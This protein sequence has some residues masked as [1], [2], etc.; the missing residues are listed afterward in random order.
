MQQAP[1][2]TPLSAADCK[3]LELL[4]SISKLLSQLHFKTLLG[5][6]ICFEKQTLT[7]LLDSFQDADIITPEQR[8]N[9]FKSL[10]SSK[11]LS[12]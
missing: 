10:E 3:H 11:W 1:F 4:H 9:F 6:C 5:N 7:M 2:P 8:V 12:H